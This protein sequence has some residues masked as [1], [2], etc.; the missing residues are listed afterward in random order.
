MSNTHTKAFGVVMLILVSLGLLMY[1]QIPPTVV[2]TGLIENVKRF[3]SGETI[4][5]YELPTLLNEEQQMELDKFA[6]TEFFSDAFVPQEYSD[7]AEKQ[8][9]G[10]R[11]LVAE[12]GVVPEGA[13]LEQSVNATEAERKA[14]EAEQ[15]G[16]F[17]GVKASELTASRTSTTL[18]ENAVTESTHVRGSI[19]KVAGK[20]DMNIK[21]PPYFYNIHMTCCE[22]DTFRVVSSVETDAHG[23]FVVKVPTTGKFPLGKWIITIGTIGDDN[24]IIK[25]QYIFNLIE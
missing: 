23:N 10:Q 1:L 18:I 12:Q 4:G 20:I 2:A 6:V 5:I 3:P 22:M 15:S 14:L 25:H 11:N 9:S 7:K 13:E 16:E 21:Q 19:V 8:I 24:T 17:T